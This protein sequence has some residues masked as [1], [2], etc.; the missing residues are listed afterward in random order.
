MRYLLIDFGGSRLGNALNKM[1]I[2]FALMF[3]IR[4]PTPA[5]LTKSIQASTLIRL[6]NLFGGVDTQ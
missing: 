1:R 3:E 2:E 5:K 6:I 4:L